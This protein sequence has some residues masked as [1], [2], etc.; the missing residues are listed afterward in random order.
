[1]KALRYLFALALFGVPS[2]AFACNPSALLEGGGGSV[3]YKSS[4]DGSSN[5]FFYNSLIDASGAVA[6]PN[7]AALADATANPTDALLGSLNFGYNGTTWDRLRTVGTGI[8]KTDNSTVA[9]TVVDT[10]SGN[11]S[12][13]TQRM[14]IATDQPNLTTPLNT[15][16]AQINGVALTTGNGVSG[17]GVQR[18][19]VA[20]DSTYSPVLAAGSNLIGQVQAVP[21]TTGGASTC[22]LTSAA[23]TN[24]TNC[25]NAAG[26]V[27]EIRP[28]NT[29]TTI[30]YLRMYNLTTAPTCS[31]A[32]GFI[33]TIPVPPATATGGAGGIVSP[34]SFGQAYGTGIGFCLTGGGSSTDNT[35]AATGVYI[36]I[37][38]K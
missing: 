9:G 34:Q 4:L 12:A 33:E 36:T 24:A 13:G 35:N 26:Q 3:N 30:Y 6:F 19:T 27:Y 23:S 31:S 1:M 7:V 32:T 5:C 20:S 16:T 8:L 21:G 38:Y 17:T 2:L 28:V 14:V 11:K 15:N 25:K 29:T 37:L 10:N 22:Y 18:V